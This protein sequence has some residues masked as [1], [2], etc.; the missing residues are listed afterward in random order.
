MIISKNE[1]PKIDF[2]GLRIFD[3]TAHL[4]SHSSIALI[5]VRPGI[6]HRT[7]YS[8][9]SDKYY[10]VVSGELDIVFNGKKHRLR[11]FDFW[12]VEKE[13]YF[14]YENSTSGTVILIL[15]HDPRFDLEAEIFIES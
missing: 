1:I 14:S 10:F 2:E 13:C 9:K 11:Q 15:F 3:Y 6:K 4:R 5:E 8:K 12:F 7:A